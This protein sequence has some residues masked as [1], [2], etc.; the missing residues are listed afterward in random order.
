MLVATTRVS[1]RVMMEGL[2]L[3]VVVLVDSNACRVHAA[4]TVGQVGG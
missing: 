1:I 2:L 4:E 3:A